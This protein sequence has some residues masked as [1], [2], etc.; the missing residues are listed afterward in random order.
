[1]NLKQLSNI[2]GIS[3]TTVSRAL[4]GYPEVSEKTRALVLAAAQKH[5]YL[6]NTKA[7][8]LATGKSKMIGFVLPM[9]SQHEMLNPIFGDFMAGAAQT[10]RTQGYDTHFALTEND[11]QAET[12]R[13]MHAKG[14]VDGVIVQAPRENDERV[15]ILKELGLPF[16]VHGRATGKNDYHYVD[17]NNTHAFINATNFLLDLGHHRIALIN[18]NEELDFAIRRNHGYTQALKDRGIE[19]DPKL[20]FSSE[21]TEHFG[22]ETMNKLLAMDQPPTAAVASSYT[23]AIGIRRALGENGLRIGKDFSVVIHDDD[24]SYLRNGAA[25]PVFTATRSS[26]REAGKLCAQILMD[27][28]DKPNQKPKQIVLEAQLIVG[29]STGPVPQ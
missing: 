11:K 9:A 6:P 22:Y 12:Y 28:I 8:A 17:V 5:N 10:Y 2:L 20:M 26:I 14:S 7:Q 3:Q 25:Q 1:M 18:G 29:S 13:D 24:L 21:M 27:V 23:L 16:V 15:A 4:N 19:A